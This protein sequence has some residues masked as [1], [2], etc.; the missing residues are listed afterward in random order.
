MTTNQKK[1]SEGAA[2]FYEEFELEAVDMQQY[3]DKKVSKDQKPN[4]RNS[5]TIIPNRIR[6]EILSTELMEGL[7]IKAMPGTKR[8]SVKGIEHG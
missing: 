5:K 2:G 7:T 1:I 3:F 6:R 4:K 8:P